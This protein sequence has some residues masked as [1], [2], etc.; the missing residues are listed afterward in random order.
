MR[1][2][3]ATDRLAPVAAPKKVARKAA[4]RAPRKAAKTPGRRNWFTRLTARRLVI[5]RFAVALIVFATVL[6]G[7]FWAK[8][9]DLAGRAISAM[10]EAVIE[11]T[12]FSGLTLNEVVVVGRH[13]TSLKDISQA[14]G[15]RR[16]D[17]I[18]SLDLQEVRERLEKLGWVRSATITRRLPSDVHVHLAE[19]RPFALWQ[20]NRKLVLIDREGAVITA[21]NL[22]RFNALPVVVGR[23]APRHAAALFD[24]LARHPAIFQRVAAAVRVAG[25]RWDV[26][27]KNGVVARLPEEDMARSWDR[28]AAME[29]EHAILEKDLKAIDLRLSGRVTVRLGSEAAKRRKDKTSGKNRRK[30]ENT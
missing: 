13:E 6:G 21:K 8:H 11:A 27:F 5:A 24:D 22:S 10:D 15:V 30:G 2:L 28:L 20:K 7:F 12:L 17:P 23:D 3:R 19:R 16:S 25:R 18:L 29:V 4:K 14:L 9:A 1:P 26:R